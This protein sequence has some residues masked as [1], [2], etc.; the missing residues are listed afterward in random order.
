MLLIK[1]LA[2]A[3]LL[4]GAAGGTAAGVYFAV[5]RT[6]E[7]VLP[8]QAEE[9]TPTPFPV[10]TLGPVVHVVR[11]VNVTVAIPEGSSVIAIQGSGGFDVQTMELTL[12]PK[13]DT[14][15]TINAETGA[16]LEDSTRP[17]DG[18]EMDTVLA[19]LTVSPFD[20]A[21]LPWPYNGEP[22]A[23]PRVTRGRISY[24][25]PD[26]SSGIS[27]VPEIAQSTG[28]PYSGIDVSNGRSILKVN[29]RTGAVA[30][31]LMHPDDEEAFNR[32]IGAVQPAGP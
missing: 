1:P 7:E 22:P 30:I 19:T 31:L 32:F 15:V 6:E 8:R 29:V 4:A 24:I 21:T 14:G 17:Q 28:E 11:W 16:I 2:A 12:G 9:A 18:A 3:V 25:P 13:F 26:A 23:V 20:P 10:A 27:I 5:P